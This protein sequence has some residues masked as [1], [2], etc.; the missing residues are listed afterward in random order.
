MVFKGADY[1]RSQNYK[2]KGFVRGGG[3]GGGGVEVKF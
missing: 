1:S 2:K 3:E